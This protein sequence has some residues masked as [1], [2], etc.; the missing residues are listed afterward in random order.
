M[1]Q[2]P[3]AEQSAHQQILTTT[4]DLWLEGVD[5]EH[6]AIWTANPDD[7]DLPNPQRL[8]VESDAD[9]LF[10]GGAAGGGKTDLLLGLAMTRHKRSAIFRRVYPNLKAVIDRSHELA[11]ERGSYNG[12]DRR[13]RISGRVIDFGA[14]QYED[15]KKNWQGRPY[16]FYG[17]DEITEFTRTQF[18][19]VSA[20]NRS[21]DP[22]QKCRIVLAG[23]PPT[24]EGGSW[25]IEEF[26]PWLDPEFE[27]K[28]APGQPLWY[29]RDGDHIRWLD[30]GDPIE[31]SG[32]TIYPRSRT[33]IPARL[34]DNPHLSSDPRYRSVLQSLPEPLRSLLLSGDFSVTA[35]AN[36]WQVIPTEWVR[37]AQRRWR[38]GTRPDVALDAVGLDVSRGGR[39]KTAAA[40]LYDYW[41][42]LKAW[43]GREMV[44]GPT[45]A[46]ATRL[47]IGK[48]EPDIINVDVIGVGSSPYDSLSEM[49][50]IPG[51]SSQKAKQVVIPVTAS[52]KSDYHDR[53]GKLSMRDMRS[54][55]HWRLREDLDPELRTDVCLP[56]GNELLAD[57]CAANYSVAAGG[58]IV[59][60]GKHKIKE[61]I[62]RS[63]DVGEAVML[64]NLPRPRSKK[65]KAWAF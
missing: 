27:P 57:L 46:E 7:G 42:E 58:K 45:V 11:D 26:A 19:F 62:G 61:R 56:P 5:L 9:E 41:F 43:P 24:D 64:A 44:D 4:E 21:T 22:N 33:F 32:E 12:A 49:Y 17:F 8:A 36:P 16:D 34:S 1:L 20:W 40:K 55:Y 39:D 30:A 65:K 25:V 13:W 52:G 38:E 23:N 59:I 18:I 2:L 6:K 35:E 3:T 54:E 37:A 47:F 60:E 31:V 51:S 53:S 10:Y 48:D 63:P 28:A 50:N 29:Y 15:D 14:M